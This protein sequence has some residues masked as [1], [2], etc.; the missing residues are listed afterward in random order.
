MARRAADKPKDAIDEAKYLFLPVSE[1]LTIPGVTAATR[2]ARSS[3]D[4]TVANRR[5]PATFIGVDRADFTQVA[6][7]RSDYAGE[8]LGALMNRLAD[9]PSSLLVS[10]DF[11][12][13][14]GLRVGDKITLAD[15]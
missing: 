10:T 4:A 3:V 11:A 6:R 14:Q 7:W 1:Y 15:E 5:T 13:K 2:V 12:A 8:S 9:D